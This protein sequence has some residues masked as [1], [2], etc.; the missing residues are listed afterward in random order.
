MTIAPTKDAGLFDALAIELA[1]TPLRLVTVAVKNLPE[2]P[3]PAPAALIESVRAF[4]LLSPLVVQRASDIGPY[5]VLAGRRR[6]DALKKLAIEYASAWLV[7][8]GLSDADA[9]TLVENWT[10]SDNLP[11][12]MQAVMKLRETHSCYAIADALHADRRHIRRLLKIAAANKDIVGFMIRGLIP[13]SIA[14][15]VSK[16]APEVQDRLAAKMIA[17]GALTFRDIKEA[18]L[19]R[20]ANAVAALPATLFAIDTTV[21]R[22]GRRSPA[23]IDSLVTT[24]RRAFQHGNEEAQIVAENALRAALNLTQITTEVAA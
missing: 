19:A 1:E 6:T 7:P 15:A 9:I 17:S 11:A 21:K 14:E 4:G 8:F 16:L 3:L 18:Q 10:R 20:A 2:S 24:M 22:E 13:A 23:E 12:E 5:R